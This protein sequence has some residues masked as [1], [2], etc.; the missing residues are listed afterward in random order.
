[1]RFKQKVTFISL[2]F[3][4]AHFFTEKLERERQRRCCRPIYETQ[5][6]S[7]KAAEKTTFSLSVFSTCSREKMA[8]NSQHSELLMCELLKFLRLV[9]MEQLVFLQAGF[10]LSKESDACRQDLLKIQQAP[11]SA[12]AVNSR[13]SVRA[14]AL[15][16]G[17]SQ[18]LTLQNPIP[19]SL[20]GDYTKNNFTHSST[21]HRCKVS[22]LEKCS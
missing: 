16:A 19:N 2:D 20:F 15:D 1:M 7:Q 5:R 4:T 17:S 10:V 9:L 8:V 11:A 6:A 14:R 21:L 12:P 13:E 22:Q 3:S 18:S